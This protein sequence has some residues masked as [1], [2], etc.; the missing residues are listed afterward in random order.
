MIY[1]CVTPV[2]RR[3][4]VLNTKVDV[5]THKIIVGFLVFAPLQEVV[6]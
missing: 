3:D 2:G 1:M 5:G 4:E 6:L